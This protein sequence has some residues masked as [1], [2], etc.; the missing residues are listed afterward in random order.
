MHS[1]Q[2]WGKDAEFLCSPSSPLFPNLQMF[3]NPE[4][5]QILS[6]VFFYGG[7]ITEALL[8]KSL[9]SDNGFNFQALSSPWR[10]GLGDIGLKSSNSNHMTGC[11]SNKPPFIGVVQKSSH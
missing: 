3:T 6:F 2:L 8:I 11:P 5:F 4:A 10:W 7:F 9:A 1:V